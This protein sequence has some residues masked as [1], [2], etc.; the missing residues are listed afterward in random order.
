MIA[1]LGFVIMAALT[2]NVDI[3]PQQVGPDDYLV[4]AS[5]PS[6]GR[7]AAKKA[8]MEKIEAHCA[9]MGK[10]L[11]VSDFES[12]DCRSNGNCRVWKVRYAC[13]NASEPRARFGWEGERSVKSSTHSKE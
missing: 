9:S 13:L 5:M 2:A 11:R 12:E 4:S 6:T 8:V 1:D 3:H 7:Q 10:V